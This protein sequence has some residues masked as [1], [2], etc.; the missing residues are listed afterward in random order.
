MPEHLLPLSALHAAAPGVLSVVFGK[1]GTRDDAP[2]WRAPI[3]GTV[4][5]SDPGF[6]TMSSL[7]IDSEGPKVCAANIDRAFSPMMRDGALDL[8]IPSIACRLAGLCLRATGDLPQRA[9]LDL[10][11]EII[12]EAMD[13]RIHP[14][15][16][17]R[18]VTLTLRLAPEIAALGGQS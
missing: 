18:M 5:G 8:T 15:T 4:A 6:Y 10:C 14:E 2:L 16:A 7:H 13:N 3:W 12:A 1:D 11:W 17:A 9:D